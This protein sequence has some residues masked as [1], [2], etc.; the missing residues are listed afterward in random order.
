MKFPHLIHSLKMELDRR[1]PRATS[2]QD[3]FWDFVSLMPEGMHKQRYMSG[4]F[5]FEPG[6]VTRSA[7]RIRMLEHLGVIRPDLGEAIADA[8][9]ARPSILFD[10][11]II[12]SSDQ[13]VATLAKGAAAID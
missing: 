1:F 6:K 9:Y 3:T 2:A 13:G 8:I 11:V 10:A 5:A 12:A 7:I 4:A